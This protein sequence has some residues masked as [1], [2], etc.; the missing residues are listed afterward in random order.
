MENYQGSFIVKSA[1]LLSPF[2][3]VRPKELSLMKWANIDL[4]KKQ[5]L[6]PPD[7]MKMNIAHL[8]PLCHQA[9]G[10]LTEI[11]P[12]TGNDKYV[13]QGRNPNKSMS[14]ASV[15]VALKKLG[16]QGKIVSHGFRSMASTILNEHGFRYDVIEKQLAHQERNAIRNAYNH[17]QYIQERKDMMDWWGEYLECLKN[18]NN[19]LM[20]KKVGG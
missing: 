8:V 15:N 7:D 9:I 6:I 17:A 11:K 20:L 19:I 13:F 1:L 10:I 14:S 5:W 12:L 18:Q 4:N 3:F 16:Y 2:V